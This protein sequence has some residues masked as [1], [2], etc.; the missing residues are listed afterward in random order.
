MTPALVRLR[1]DPT[2][3]RVSIRRVSASGRDVWVAHAEERAT[4]RF[5]TWTD[6]RPEAAVF[7]AVESAYTGGLE[8][9]DPLMG[10]AYKHPFGKSEAA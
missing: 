8:G 9:A 4:G 6:L 2:K 10:W 3:L 7:G 1:A 5:V